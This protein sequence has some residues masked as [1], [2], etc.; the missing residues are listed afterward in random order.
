MFTN[1]VESDLLLINS[2]V[3]QGSILVTFLFLIYINDLVN[4]TNYFSI[5]YTTSPPTQ[6][7]SFFRNYPFIYFS[8][9]LVADDTSLTVTCKALVT[10]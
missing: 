5:L 8:I 3:P 2:G 10:L 6:H 7:H 9:R 1:G 4:A